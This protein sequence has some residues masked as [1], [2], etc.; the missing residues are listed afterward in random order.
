[1]KSSRPTK[2]GEQLPSAQCRGQGPWSNGGH[3]D[4]KVLQ[5]PG[6][7]HLCNRCPLPLD[8]GMLGKVMEFPT[9]REAR[10]I[11]GPLSISKLVILTL[12]Q[13]PRV[14]KAQDLK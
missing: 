4:S 3:E 2:D 14:G 13:T 9:S 5:H 1:M 11:P 10:T 8:P 12:A 7:I 6:C